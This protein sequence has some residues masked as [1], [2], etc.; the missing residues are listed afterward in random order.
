MREACETKQAESLGNEIIQPFGHN[1][2]GLIKVHRELGSRY[3]QKEGGLR[4]Y[5]RR[6]SETMS[7]KLATGIVA[8]CDGG[9]DA[10]GQR[11]LLGQRI[12][13]LNLSQLER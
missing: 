13:S 2:D 4:S 5:R 3:L 10:D 8:A 11:D 6:L 12:A 1:C 9:Y 7:P